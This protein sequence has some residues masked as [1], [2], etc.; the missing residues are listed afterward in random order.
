[1]N[2]YG[3]NQTFSHHL[4]WYEGRQFEIISK[5]PFTDKKQQE[6]EFKRP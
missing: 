1:M 2:S 6:L 5:C 3:I 4:L